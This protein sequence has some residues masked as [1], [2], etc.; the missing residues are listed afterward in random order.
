MGRTTTHAPMSHRVLSPNQKYDTGHNSRD[1]QPVHLCG[2]IFWFLEEQAG[3]LSSNIYDIQQ[4]IEDDDECETPEDIEDKINFWKIQHQN[5]H[6]SFFNHFCQFKMLPNKSV[7]QWTSQNFAYLL[8]N[9][10]LYE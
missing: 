1:Q 9:S 10:T 8:T 3:V 7:N 2:S 5:L 4:D 6:V